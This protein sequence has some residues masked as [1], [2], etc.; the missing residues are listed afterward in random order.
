M[1]QA[2][3]ADAGARTFRLLVYGLIPVSSATQF[4]L[5]LVMP[6]TP[7]GSADPD[8]SREWRPV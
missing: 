2:I 5:V 3:R 4:A 6:S 8:S 1:P 7:T